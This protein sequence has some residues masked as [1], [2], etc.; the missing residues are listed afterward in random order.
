MDSTGEGGGA[1]WGGGVGWGGLIS[2]MS[3]AEPCHAGGWGGW[4]A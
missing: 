1:G 2:S 3:L 4:G